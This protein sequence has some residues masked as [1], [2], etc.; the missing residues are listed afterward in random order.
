MSLIKTIYAPSTDSNGARIIA[1]Q[2]KILI[3]MPYDFAIDYKSNHIAAAKLLRIK[4][5]SNN[6]MVFCKD[7]DDYAFMFSVDDNGNSL[8]F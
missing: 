3:K 4:I 5:K 8:A 7:G 6:T 2:G 1:K